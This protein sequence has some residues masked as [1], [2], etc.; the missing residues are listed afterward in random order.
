[1]STLCHELFHYERYGDSFELGGMWTVDMPV[2][3]ELDNSDKYFNYADKLKA[4]KN[5]ALFQNAYNI[6][7]YF[8]I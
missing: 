8:E 5:P 1:M 7:H 4:N 6:E 3:R 2:D